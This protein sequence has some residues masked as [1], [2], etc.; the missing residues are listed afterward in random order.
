MQQ[1]TMVRYLIL[2]NSFQRSKAATYVDYARHKEQRG[3]TE[4]SPTSIFLLCL[5]E[6]DY[7]QNL[8]TIKSLQR[9]KKTRE[10]FF[11]LPRRYQNTG[12]CAI[13]VPLAASCVLRPRGQSRWC[14]SLDPTGI[15]VRRR[16]S[17][18]VA[19]AAFLPTTRRPSAAEARSVDEGRL[20]MPGRSAGASQSTVVVIVGPLLQLLPPLLLLPI[21]L[22]RKLD[23][24]APLSSVVRKPML[25]PDALLRDCLT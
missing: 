23:E 8:S 18:T 2:I 7:K 14:R 24:N 6:V 13:K 4:T 22:P 9:E 25:L 1:H 17:A 3:N 5:C 21:L 19:G 15:A 16:R 10:G 20:F 11:R 12:R